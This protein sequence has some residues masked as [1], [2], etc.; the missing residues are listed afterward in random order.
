[1]VT[2]AIAPRTLTLAGVRAEIYASQAEAD[3]DPATNHDELDALEEAMNR[4]A[5]FI[6]DRYG[7]SE[8]WDTTDGQI[9]DLHEELVSA[10]IGA[11]RGAMIELAAFRLIGTRRIEA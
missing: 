9:G 8:G 1:M 2:T 11:A 3:A 5:H 6:L 4:E 7:R 10:G